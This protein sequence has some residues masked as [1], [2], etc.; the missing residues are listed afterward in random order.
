MI[1]PAR[2]AGRWARRGAGINYIMK[3]EGLFQPEAR[4][5]IKTLKP[6]KLAILGSSKL[7]LMN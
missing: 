6:M 2:T 7:A 4:R 5:G 3:A 1:I